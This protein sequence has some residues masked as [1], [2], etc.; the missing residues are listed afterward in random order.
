MPTEASYEGIGS[1]ELELQTV[2]S[3]HVDSGNQTWVRQCPLLL[4][5]HLSRCWLC[6]CTQLCPITDAY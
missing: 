1:Q 4:L 2:V 5:S 3:C 6:H